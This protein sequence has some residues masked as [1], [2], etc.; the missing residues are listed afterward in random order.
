MSR[1]KIVKKIGKKESRRPQSNEG[2]FEKDELLLKNL[3]DYDE[4]SHE[5][6][7]SIK[8]YTNDDNSTIF[9]ILSKTKAL[10][11]A[12]ELIKIEDLEDFITFKVFLKTYVKDWKLPKQMGNSNTTIKFGDISLTVSRELYQKNLLTFVKYGQCLHYALQPATFTKHLAK[13]DNDK[14]RTF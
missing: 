12:S 11:L 9:D 10:E 3:I 4:I 14:V 13:D 2:I 6:I 1:D 8:T 7:A 5:W